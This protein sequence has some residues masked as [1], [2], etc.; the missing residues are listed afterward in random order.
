MWITLQKVS[1][2]GIWLGVAAAA[3]VDAA[4]FEQRDCQ[5][6]YSPRLGLMLRLTNKYTVDV[7]KLLMY[8]G[9]GVVRRGDWVKRPAP[10][11]ALILLLNEQ[12]SM[13]FQIKRLVAVVGSVRTGSG[14]PGRFF[15]GRLHLGFLSILDL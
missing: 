14:R 3:F 5:Y 9:M 8:V 7:L 12:A 13:Q 1:L 6:L 2:S 11:C 4:Q 10:V 15:R